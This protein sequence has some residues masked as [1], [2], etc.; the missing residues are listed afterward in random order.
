M[1]ELEKARQDFD[2][3]RQR[4]NEIDN[5]LG[6]TMHKIVGLRNSLAEC[7]DAQVMMR[8]KQEL[9]DAEST[10]A[11]LA[12][13]NAHAQQEARLAKERMKEAEDAPR[14]RQAEIQK[15][16][17]QLHACSILLKEHETRI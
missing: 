2:A 15:L 12:R 6:Q 14:A 16:R 7:Q 3:A 17:H 5:Q 8:M 1:S 10:H 4:A 9:A 11:A 13:Q